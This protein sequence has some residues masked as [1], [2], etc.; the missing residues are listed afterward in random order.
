MWQKTLL[1]SC[2]LTR[3]HSLTLESAK[4]QISRY[5]GRLTKSDVLEVI[6][7]LASF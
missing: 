2:H 4:C 7:A 6:Y 3:K 5:I 1:M